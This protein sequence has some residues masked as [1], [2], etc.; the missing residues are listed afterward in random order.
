MENSSVTMLIGAFVALIIGVSL[1]GVIASEGNDVTN[2][3]TISSEEIDYTTAVQVNGTI[4]TSVEYTIANVPD[5]WRVLGCPISSFD[6][7]NS[8]S[9]LTAVDYTFNTATGVI[10]FNNSANVNG[11]ATNTTTATYAY[12]NEGYLTQGWNRSVLNLVPGFFALALMGIGI[13]LFY[14]IIRKEGILN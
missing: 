5:G 1:I 11:T 10:T 8:S 14:S 12:C 6:L 4:N 13:G 3:I 2:M 7:Y 9:S